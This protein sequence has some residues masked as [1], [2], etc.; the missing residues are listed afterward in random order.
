MDLNRPQ[1]KRAIFNEM[2]P[3]EKIDDIKGSKFT[4]MNFESFVSKNAN[5]T[6]AWTYKEKETSAQI[7]FTHREMKWDTGGVIKTGAN[8]STGYSKEFGIKYNNSLGPGINTEIVMDNYRWQKIIEIES[9]ESLG[10]IPKDAKYLEISFD[11]S[12]N[13]ELPDGIISECIKFGDDSYLLPIHAW[14][15][16]EPPEN[17]EEEIP[18]GA[19]GNIIENVLTKQIPVEWLRNVSYPVKTDVTI[20]YGDE[21]IFNGTQTTYISVAALDSTHFVVAYKDDGSLNYGCARVGLVSGKNI[22]S[23]GAENVFN[24]ANTYFISVAALDSTHFVVAYRDY[25]DAE[26][27]SAIARVGL[28]D[29]GTTISSY[30]AENVFNAVATSGISIS[31]FDSTHFVIAYNDYGGDEYG[32]ARVGLTDGGTTISSYGAEN[33][34]N[35]ASTTHIS[36]ATL[37]T[38]HFVVVYQDSGGSGYGIA[39]VGLT[40]G[41]TTISSYGAE[42]VFNTITTRFCSVAALD[43]THFVV[44]YDYQLGDKY[45]GARIGIV[46]GTTISSYGDENIFNAGTTI[47]AAVSALDSTH[48]VVS[49][50]DDSNN[51][52]GTARIGTV[53]GTTII[54]YT[55]E[56]VFNAA[57]ID[58][59]SIATLDST[60]FVVTYEDYGGD[61]YGIAR[62]G[63]PVSGWAGTINGITNPVSI[64]G[65]D[66]VNIALVNGI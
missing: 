61:N 45:G 7:G 52:Y 62:I 38:T 26:N 54:S 32:I 64:I 58:S 4:G 63:E 1:I 23:Y 3:L 39:R 46:S 17:P 18:I 43:S 28:T 60:Y 49:Y 10:I 53:S 22:S 15:L 34:F 12:G 5:D 16:S 2:R 19:T 27:D 57:S 40:D 65:I 35:T 66:V 41:G 6:D 13:V 11:V 29:G 9:L 21:N 36:V 25:V 44:G 8:K 24:A 31:S 47:F 42:N 48:F 56:S 59:L 50:R 55:D 51:N 37:D 30:G 14:D 20:S 33:I